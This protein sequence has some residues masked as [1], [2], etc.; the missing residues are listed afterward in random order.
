MIGSSPNNGEARKLRR[1]ALD[2]LQ[3][4]QGEYV[5]HAVWVF[6]MKCE[7]NTASTSLCLDFV[8]ILAADRWR[9]ESAGRCEEG[10][11]VDI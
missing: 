7:G 2:I 6:V 1:R 4:C 9:I 10:G 5:V 8:E 11:R 3:T